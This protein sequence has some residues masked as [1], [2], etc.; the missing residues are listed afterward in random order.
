M[1][2]NNCSTAKDFLE[3]NISSFFPTIIE[4]VIGGLL[5]FRKPLYDELMYSTVP[6]R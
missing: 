5:L 3:F 6:F 2:T 1:I 4:E